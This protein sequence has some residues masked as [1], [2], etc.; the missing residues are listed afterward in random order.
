[1]NIEE[2]IRLLVAEINDVQQKIKS[3]ENQIIVLQQRYQALTLSQA[4]LDGALSML[5][6]MQKESE[7]VK[8]AS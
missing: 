7:P 2:R 8:E 3:V 1:M 4:R 5:T 6:N